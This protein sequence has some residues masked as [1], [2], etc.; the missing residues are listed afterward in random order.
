MSML[1]TVD[2]PYDP[3]TQY[4][5]WL[6]YDEQAGYNTNEA[7]ESAIDEIIRTDPIGL[8]IKMTQKEHKI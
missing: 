7:I 1:T 6:S 3:Y 4:D 2:N 5:E 8:Y